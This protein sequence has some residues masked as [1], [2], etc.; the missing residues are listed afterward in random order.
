MKRLIGLIRFAAI[1]LVMAAVIQQLQRPARE[2]TWTGHILGVP[3]DFRPPTLQ[4]VEQRWWNPDNPH[5]LTPHV[6]GIGWGVNLYQVK[7]YL[8]EMLR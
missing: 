4:R 2:R 3:Y 1:A 5:L 7:H 6:F 8:E